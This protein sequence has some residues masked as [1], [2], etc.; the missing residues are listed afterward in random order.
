MK[1]PEDPD[2]RF[3]PR[4]GVPIVLPEKTATVLE[5][6]AE[7]ARLTSERLNRRTTLIIMV[8]LCIIV[9]FF[10][11]L[12]PINVSEAKE[13]F[14]EYSKVE[15]A[16]N[17]FGVAIIYGNNLMHNVIMFTP[18]IGPLYGLYVLFSTGRFIA[19]LALLRGS[20][21]V[22]LMLSVLA[23]PHA[24]I[25]Y[26]SYALA[27]SES[28]WLTSMIIKHRLKDEAA[29]FFKTMSMCALLLLAAAFIEMFLINYLAGFS[30]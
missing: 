1:L 29:V 7:K 20:N 2:A 11:A 22:I 6:T 15:E 16:I 13:R 28:Y 21:P 8:L 18:L 24:W 17:N 12:L 9:T 19:A 30:S 26:L 25:E 14:K 5:P 27:M 10:G 4:C 3:C 23:F